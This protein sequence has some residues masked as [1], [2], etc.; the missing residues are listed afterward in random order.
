MDRRLVDLEQRF[1]DLEDRFSGLEVSVNT[2]HGRIT[3]QLNDVQTQIGDPPKVDGLQ[4]KVDDMQS[5]VEDILTTM[6]NGFATWTA[7]FK[8]LKVRV[9]ANEQNVIVGF[10][11]SAF[12]NRPSDAVM[13]LFSARTGIAIPNFPRTS[14]L[15]EQ[16]PLG[17]ANNILHEL[18][19]QPPAG[20]ASRY[21]P[22][23][24]AGDHQASLRHRPNLISCTMG[25]GSPWKD[26]DYGHGVMELAFA[27]TH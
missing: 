19:I 7:S 8:T 2:N 13:A 20:I 26:I 23:N 4:T 17:A 22:L 27:F 18:D 5:K 1:V 16:L 21:H 12:V 6:T 25:H 14:A 3:R 15:V 11:N 10:N 24:E 9:A